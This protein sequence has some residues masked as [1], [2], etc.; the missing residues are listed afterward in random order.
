VIGLD[1]L[2]KT[3]GLLPDQDLADVAA[4]ERIAATRQT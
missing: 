4:L 3:S 2:L 1:A